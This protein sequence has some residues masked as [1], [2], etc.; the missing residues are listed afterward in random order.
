MPDKLL[1][2]HT[3]RRFFWSPAVI[4]CCYIVATLRSS[5]CHQWDKQ[6]CYKD[7]QISFKSHNFRSSEVIILTRLMAFKNLQSLFSRLYNYV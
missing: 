2:F 1:S 3:K 6:N 5:F 4:L 7:F